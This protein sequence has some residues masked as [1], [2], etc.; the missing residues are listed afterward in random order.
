MCIHFDFIVKLFINQFFIFFL[1]ILIGAL[2]PIIIPNKRKIMT[3]NP[4][5]IPFEFI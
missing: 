5:P 1:K 4:N 3:F 2:N